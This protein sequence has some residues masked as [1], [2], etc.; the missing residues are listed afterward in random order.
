M[1]SVTA[2][3]FCQERTEDKERE[4]A[5]R[6]TTVQFMKTVLAS[7]VLCAL[8]CSLPYIPQCLACTQSSS[9]QARTP[10][11]VADT[12]YTPAAPL[13]RNGAATLPPA[14]RPALTSLVCPRLLPI[15]DTAAT[16]V[17]GFQPAA[18]R[19]LPPP[20]HAF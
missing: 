15:L 17:I 14:C 20:E 19:P 13:R 7:I 1:H 3:Y 10:Y 11:V 9:R 8:S 16:S 6:L 18:A 12:S 2:V 4:T 5:S